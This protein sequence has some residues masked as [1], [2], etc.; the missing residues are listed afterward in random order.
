MVAGRQR[1]S[2]SQR[3][4]KTSNPLEKTSKDIVPDSLRGESSINNLRRDV[5]IALEMV[6]KTTHGIG[7]Y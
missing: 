4:S 6:L 3:G 2:V 1:A 7:I 5:C